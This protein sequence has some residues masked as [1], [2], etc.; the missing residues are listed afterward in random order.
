MPRQAPAVDPLH[1]EVEAPLAVDLVDRHDVRVVEAG[2]RL[3]LEE[4]PPPLG[5]RGERAG[6]DDLQR[7]DAVEAPLAGLV[8][9]AHAAPRDLL[10]QLE[11]AEVQAEGGRSGRRRPRPG[12]GPGRRPRRLGGGGIGSGLGARLV[13]LPRG[14]EGRRDRRLLSREP[15]EVILE[16]RALAPT[17][18]QL[19]LEREQLG[20]QFG[21]LPGRPPAEFV[22]DPRPPSG[23]PGGLVPLAR[24]VDAPGPRQRVR[25]GL[26]R[27]IDRHG[28]GPPP[29]LSWV[30]VRA[31][32]PPRGGCPQFS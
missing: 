27:A 12:R 18:A 5:L 2:R 7:D 28:D 14:A 8:D 6:L 25:L 15:G 3:G 16:R 20:Q 9:D 23:S 10:Q 29:G 32:G 17:P 11:V 31:P 1:G 30:T 21:P 22:L 19:H 24:R 13:P 26:L 4:E